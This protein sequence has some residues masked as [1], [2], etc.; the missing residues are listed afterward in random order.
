MFVVS[1]QQHWALFVAAGLGAGIGLFVAI[2]LYGDSARGRL[3]RRVRE[4]RQQYT[5][6]VQAANRVQRAE[7][8]LEKLG[9]RADSVKPRRMQ[10]ARVALE[11][12]QALARI[13]EDRVLIAENQVRKLIVE[14]FPPKRQ[15]ALRDRFLRRPEFD[16]RPFR[17]G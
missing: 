15:E 10:E 16:G 7:K 17:F 3:G 9:R 1:F 8:R 2:R 14:E 6:L 4:L 11:D 12:A 5:E 13:V